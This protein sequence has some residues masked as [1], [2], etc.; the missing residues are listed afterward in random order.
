M[1][2]PI[3]VDRGTSDNFRRQRANRRIRVATANRECA[4]GLGEERGGTRR[5]RVGRRQRRSSVRSGG[6]VCVNAVRG[7]RVS[8][9]QST[10]SAKGQRHWRWSTNEREVGDSHRPRDRHEGRRVFTSL[11]N[12]SAAVA[13]EQEQGSGVERRGGEW[14][15]RRVRRH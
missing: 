5:Q 1:E 13:V 3:G 7:F 14:W 12:C 9:R 11:Q 6:T 4:R 10:F 8:R 2:R 15:G